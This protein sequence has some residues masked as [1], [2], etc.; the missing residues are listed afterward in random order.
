ML[1]H[2]NPMLA[3]THCTELISR[4]KLMTLAAKM[5]S[6][7]ED[8]ISFVSVTFANCDA[9]FGVSTWGHVVTET[10]N[11]WT[12]LN[13]WSFEL[14]PHLTLYGHKTAL[15]ALGFYSRCQEQVCFWYLS[16]YLSPYLIFFD[17]SV[18]N[19]ILLR[20]YSFIAKET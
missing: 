3:L 5:F 15:A 9:M 19:K 16:W 12:I 10:T 14:W 17:S 2:V 1:R 11:S 4:W 7:F 18:Q 13:P 6:W 20:G 8:I